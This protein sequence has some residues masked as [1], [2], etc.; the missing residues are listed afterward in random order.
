MLSQMDPKERLGYAALLGVLLFGAGYVGAQHLKSAPEVKIEM[1]PSDAPD[2][3]SFGPAQSNPP[4]QPSV[5]V[6]DVAGAVR[7]PRVLKLQPG[8]RVDEA[9][10]KAGGA[11]PDADLEQL[12]LA[13]KLED[14]TQLYVP[15]R[16][17]GQPPQATKVAVPYQGGPAAE[18][19]YKAS[20]SRAAASSQGKGRLP[21]PN[22]ISVN[23][24]SQA[25]LE[26][27]PG[28]G[29]VTAQRII[30]YRQQR[31]GFTAV[32]ELLNVKGIGPKKLA[33]IRPYVKL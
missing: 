28:I 5:I 29:P 4:Q 1:T 30:E 31:G 19:P 32:E 3:R 26:R 23:S 12:N 10:S 15:T 7:S 18:T 33:E 11:R 8:A 22:S 17:V 27:L 20:P 9:I 13:A 21:A 6:V 25:D 14:G 16:P 24:G 2:A